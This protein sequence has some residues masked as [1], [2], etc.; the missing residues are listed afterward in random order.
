MDKDRIAQ[1]FLETAH[2][3]EISGENPFKVRA[4]E[5]AARTIESLNNFEELS[6]SG[7]L[8]TIKGLGSSILEK[9][10]E[11]Q[12]TGHLV[13][14]EQL[15]EKTPPGLI[16]MMKVPTL[17]PKKVIIL[18]HELGIKSIQE[19]EQ[20][21]L[22]NRLLHIEKFGLKTQQNIME[23]ISFLKKY[24]GTY[25][26]TDGI[27]TANKLVAHMKSL[28]E[29]T[30]I[31]VAGSIRRRKEIVRDIDIVA[32]CD[33]TE[34]VMD[35]FVSLP[36]VENIIA[37]GTTKSTISLRT[38][39]NCDLRVVSK[40]EYPYTLHHL[41]GSKDHNTAMRGRA[42]KMG[43]KMNEYGLFREDNTNIPCS[44]E[45]EI[46]AALGLDFIPPELRENL[47]EI[48]AAETG[49]LPRLIEKKDI[50]GILHC[51]T[52]WSDGNNTL[53]EMV[54]ACKN[55]GYSYIGITD[56]SVTASYAGGLTIEQ[57]HR[58]LEEIE[59]L[60]KLHYPFRVF[61]GVEL[62]ILGDGSLDYNP[63]TLALY[64]FV[65]ASVHS[66][67][68]LSTEDMTKRICRALENPYVTILG[69]PTG[70]LLLARKE[71]N[72]D[73]ATILS[74]AAKNHKAIELNANPNRFDLDWRYC[75]QAKELGIKIFINPDAH[76]MESMHYVELGVDI[77]RKG[78]LEAHDVGNTM[79]VAD[80]EKYFRAVS[81]INI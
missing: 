54:T 5:N 27:N 48:E 49:S 73:M 42:K 15:K 20:A 37:K 70:R 16:E 76:N 51:H 21:C 75:K 13:Y 8:K 61:K 77:A 81:P 43:L 29:V 59:I 58:Q 12:T 79:D 30:S 3:L 65:I 68:N 35:F 60:N 36:T 71:Y 14:Y 55:S 23:G 66:R 4:Y 17:G 19:L 32:T 39:M 34:K 25:L 1:I 80:L 64:D 53:E 62:D 45:K 44:S 24:S 47:G 50:K 46:F 22:E 63:E 31:E 10:H 28:P 7:E 72:V 11:L 67:F 56:H 78:W 2:L 69:H 57:V 52:T 6:I 26:L 41:T 18:Y 38:G 74:C 40:E 33:N 9:I